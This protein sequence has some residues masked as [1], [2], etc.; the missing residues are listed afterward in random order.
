M[1]LA[2]RHKTELTYAEPITESVMELRMMPRTDLHQTLRSFELVLGPEAPV[3]QHLDW[4]G[5]HAHH[6][7]IVDV[8]DRV[9][10]MAASTVETHPERIR[11][12]EVPD[13]LPFASLGHRFQDLLIP[14]GAVQRD[15]RLAQFAENSG[16]IPEKRAAMVLAA[17]TARL[18]ELITYTKGVTKSSTRVADVLDLGKGV[19]Q[20]FAHVALSLL[21][22]LGIP[23]R[24]VSGYLFRPETAELE[25]HAWVEA[26]V[27][28]IGWIG[29]DPTHGQLAGE[30]HVSVAVG[31]SYADV[32]PNRGVYRGGAEEKIDVS[33]RIQKLRDDAEL[34]SSTVPRPD[35]RLLR[36]RV[37]RERKLDLNALEQQRQQQQQQQQ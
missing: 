8:H 14:H 2:I 32:P 7:S 22:S 37:L 9:V 4:Q 29:L 27:P 33:V 17:V 28:S 34:A 36:D 31:R 25:T 16:L 11:L 15:P 1:L 21:R 13:L 23:S 26:F 20:D 12:Q 30:A 19:C 10:I 24:Y 35:V 3:F 18:G 5:N 6:F